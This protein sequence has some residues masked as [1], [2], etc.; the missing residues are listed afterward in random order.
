MIIVERIR[1]THGP[2]QDERKGGFYFKILGIRESAPR[3]RFYRGQ[4][5]QKYSLKDIQI[6]NLVVTLYK[7]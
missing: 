1:K 6:L 2:W 4:S 5:L 3:Y 7:L